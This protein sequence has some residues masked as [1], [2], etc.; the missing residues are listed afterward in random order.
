MNW[1]QQKRKK[2]S[3]KNYAEATRKFVSKLFEE[4]SL[5][6][7]DGDDEKLK[8][9]FAPFMARELETSFSFNEVQNANKTLDARNIPVQVNP[10]EINLFYFRH[11][12][13]A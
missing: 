6:I 4:Y 3:G 7:V 13:S 8:R 10:R 12:T 1:V 11:F 2:Y 9:S 5:L